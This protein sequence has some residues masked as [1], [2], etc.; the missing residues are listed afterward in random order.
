MS[1][2]M[3]INMPIKPVATNYNFQLKFNLGSCQDPS[4]INFSYIK[5]TVVHVKGGV[6]IANGPLFINKKLATV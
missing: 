2:M 1:A 5:K 6:N 4:G 3:T